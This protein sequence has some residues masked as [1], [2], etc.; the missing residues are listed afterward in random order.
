MRRDSNLEA[1]GVLRTICIKLAQ[2]ALKPLSKSILEVRKLV[3]FIGKFKPGGQLF[4]VSEDGI[5]HLV[6]ELIE[7]QINF[8][9]N[10]VVKMSLSE[11]LQRIACSVIVEIQ[12][13]QCHVF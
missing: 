5:R 9:L 2:S 6:N 8:G 10:L 1:G 4:V 13:K 7:A 12:L 3:A 11:V